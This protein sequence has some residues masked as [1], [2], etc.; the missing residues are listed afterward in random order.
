MAH[1][2]E[3]R[4]VRYVSSNTAG[5]SIGYSGDY[6]AR[7]AREQKIRATRIGRQWFVDPISLENFYA[8]ANREKQ[9]RQKKLREVRIKERRKSEAFAVRRAELLRYAYTPRVAEA[10]QYA[11]PAR[12]LFAST[13]VMLAGVFLGV[14][15]YYGSTQSTATMVRA[16]PE[17][18]TFNIAAALHEIRGVIGRVAK[19]GAAKA[20]ESASLPALLPEGVR[21][22]DAGNTAPLDEASFSDGANGMVVIPEGEDAEAS[23][24]K[25]RAS[26]SDEVVISRDETNPETGVITPVFRERTGEQYRFL[27][28]PVAEGSGP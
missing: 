27:L 25:I 24:A 17:L 7:L 26:F 12:A 15:F 21:R 23:L 2:V 9:I 16:I 13:G 6:V 14:V 20:P 19:G 4:G 18:P 5:S 3:I 10:I 8:N 22:A 28:V 11:S 1:S